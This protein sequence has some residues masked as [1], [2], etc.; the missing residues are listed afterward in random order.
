MNQTKQCVTSH[1]S[2]L[3]PSFKSRSFLLSSCLFAQLTFI[4]YSQAAP[5]G[6]QVVGGVGTINQ[7]DLTTTIHQSTELMAI[8]WQ[9]YNVQQNERVHYIQPSSSS[10]SLNRILGSNASS[11]RGQIDANGQIILV[12]PNGVFFG[13]TATINVGGII[14]SGLDIKP[15]DFMNGNYIFN[16]VLGTDGFVINSGIINAAT[17]GSVTLLGK[18]VKNEGMISAKLGT[19]NMAAGKA[20][21]LHAEGM[22]KSV[23]VR[24]LF[25]I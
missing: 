14:A 23:V 4:S 19:V 3:H 9:S 15:S 2:K 11:I 16:E 12:N 1:T 24:M 10:I 18:Q 7:A 8:D 17:G 13:A 22:F 25:T 20:A 21:V 5:T 6:G